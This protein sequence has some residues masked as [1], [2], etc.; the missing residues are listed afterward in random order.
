MNL[1]CLLVYRLNAELLPYRAPVRQL[2]K[3]SEQSRL[4]HQKCHS[5]CDHI[6]QP[7]RDGH[8]FRRAASLSNM[9]FLL[10]IFNTYDQDPLFTN[11]TS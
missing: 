10:L 8:Y 6:Y 9:K 11:S 3:F 5:C 4:G 7:K 2:S 1:C